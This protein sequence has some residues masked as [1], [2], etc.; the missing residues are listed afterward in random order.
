MWMLV[1]LLVF[2]GWLA[3]FAQAVRGQSAETATN[4]SAKP[5]PVAAP[6]R[7]AN[8][9]GNAANST[10]NSTIPTGNAAIVN[11]QPIPEVAVYRALRAVPESEREKARADILQYLIDNTL[12]D[13]YLIQAKF[14]AEDKE[15]EAQLTQFKDEVAKQ[16]QDFT[17]VL[18]NLLLDEKELR[19]QIA[20]QIRWEKFLNQQAT[21]ANLKQLF[22][23]N[24]DMFN[25]SMVRARHILLV[26]TSDDPKAHQE[27]Q[28]QLQQL[29]QQMEQEVAQA[30]QK[31]PAELDNQ[32]KEQARSKKM[33]EVFATMAR[34]KSACPSKRDGG[35]VN[36][37]PRAGSMV[38][39]FAKAAFALK[40]F[41]I[42][43][44]IT[45]SF[46]YHLIL[47][48]DRRPGQP[49]QF[50]DVKEEVREVYGNKLR[51]VVCTQLRARSK[52][53]VV[54]MLQK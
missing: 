17:K 47:V 43:E 11:G 34:E 41:T 30:M 10:A 18:S 38:E 39:N 35:D 31:F 13:Q 53:E 32:A 27:A 2:V 4:P 9:T 7:T 54:P 44:V 51:E 50:A 33:D 52:I 49:V 20:A 1:R 21:E 23:Q 37:F 22:D 36:W 40:P 3:S 6:Q 24:I 5:E 16:K 12:L 45:T 42:S 48:T 26:P 28:N 29:K 15:I 14:V 46:G 19:E 25:G 8:S